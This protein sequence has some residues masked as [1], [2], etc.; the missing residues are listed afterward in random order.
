MALFEPALSETLRHEDSQLRGLV[1]KDP[2]ADHPDAI[3]RFGINSGANPKAVNE[4]FFEMGRDQALQYAS[5]IYKYQYFAPIG[6]YQIKD[7]V[8]ANKY[9]DLAVN[10]GVGEATKIIQRACNKF[11]LPGDE[12]IQVDGR[13]GLQTMKAINKRDPNDLLVNIKLVAVQFYR[14]WAFRNNK[15]DSLLDA[16]IAR[17]NS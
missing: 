11:C 16:L 17:V 1:T 2:S 4:G 13:C 7:Q 6:G 12:G 8:I 9:F 10:M 14:D 15:P 3:A 5:D